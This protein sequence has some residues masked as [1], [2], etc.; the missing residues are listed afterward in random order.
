MKNNLQKAWLNIWLALLCFG[1]FWVPGFNCFETPEVWQVKN[2]VDAGQWGLTKKPLELFV[3]S[4]E[5]LYYSI[6]EMGTLLISLPFA[7][8]AKFLS[9]FSGLSFEDLF[10]LMMSFVSAFV[11]ASTFTWVMKLAAE[12]GVGMRKVFL[13]L[14]SSQYMLY[15]LYPSDVS[16]AAF[17][18]VAVFALW[19]KAEQG[20]NKH[21]FWTGVLA[22]I[23]SL[24]KIPLVTAL[25]T[26]GLLALSSPGISWRQRVLRAASLSLGAL[27][28]LLVIGWWNWVRV[29][30]ALHLTSDSM[31]QHDFHWQVIFQNLLATFFSPGRGLLIFNPVFLL[32]PLLFTPRGYAFRFPRSC[33]FIFGSLISIMIRIAGTESWSGNGGWGIRYYVPWIPVLILVLAWEWQQRKNSRFWNF[34]IPLL[35]AGGILLNFSGILTNFHFREI[36]HGFGWWDFQSA[37]FQ[38]LY[39][40]PA[41]LLRTVGISIPETILEGASA[42][43][44]FVS[45]RFNV[46]WFGLQT[47]GVPAFFSWL[48]GISLALAALFFQKK[49]QANLKE[50]DSLP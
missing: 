48:I 30:H 3:R 12:K 7:Y 22:G 38:A 11:L 36:L 4:A 35:I 23:L 16:I 15:T 37:N 28:S 6:H 33:F 25:L 34:S 41:N 8:A 20:T 45:N 17:F 29:G 39:A 43:N 32:L 50:G 24:L 44:Q 2:F 47:F 14:L 27:P 1:L 19:L 9:S 21:W 26:L 42:R 13:L 46:W 31:S 5:G 49:A 10:F 40:L 18:M